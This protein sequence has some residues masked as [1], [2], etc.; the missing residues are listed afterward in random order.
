[1]ED[2]KLETNA[3]VEHVRVASPKTGRPRSEWIRGKCPKCGDDLISNAY[4]VGGRGYKIIWQCW[5]SLGETPT[6]DYQHV[7]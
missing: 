1:M 4:Y 2:I 7:L 6:C 3:V 5:A